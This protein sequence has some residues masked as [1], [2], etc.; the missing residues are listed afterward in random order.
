MLS[1]REISN[2]FSLLAKLME[3][4]GENAFKSRSN[5]NAAF[6]IGRMRQ[7]IAELDNTEL[8]KIDGIGK[9]T[10]VKIRELIDEGSIKELDALIE[11]TPAGV[12]DMMG[13][14][15]IGPKKIAVIW[16]ELGIESPGELL[17]ACNENRLI[18]LKGFGKKTQDQIIKTIEFSLSNKDK[19]HFASVEELSDDLLKVI[20]SIKECKQCSLSGDIRRK[21]IVI[22]DIQIV[23]SATDTK[24][25]YSALKKIFKDAVIDEGKSEI[26]FSADSGVPVIISV[27]TE[28][29][30]VNQV[31]AQ[32]AS[33]K[34]LADL[35]K[36]KPDFLSKKKYKNEDDIY[37]DLGLQTIPA[38]MREGIGEVQLAKKN[39]IPHLL[40]DKDLKGIL[41]NHT[42]YS[43]GLHSLRE[44]AE[45]CKKL[46]YEYLGICDHSKS[47]FYANGLHVDRIVEQHKEIDKLNEELKPFKIFKGIESDILNNGDLDY[48]PEVL[49]SF[50]MIVASI[51]SN[52]KMDSN[53]ATDRLLKAIENPFTTILG[54]PT[55]RLL[56]A[57]EGYPIDHKKV[58]D[59]CA[60]NNV[61]IELNAH[62]YRLDLD[63]SWIPYALKK[64]VMI[65]INPDAHQIEGYYDMHYGVCAARK[66]GLPADM[67][68]N[69]LGLEKIEK[70]FTKRKESAISASV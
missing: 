12:I 64:K 41:H 49:S 31:F 28:A 67:T 60:A 18:E 4:H 29:E 70:Y 26:N 66:G 1:N 17:Y 5:A 20:S 24:K 7:N 27:C 9:G 19:F 30:Y 32:T 33:E 52:L 68:F 61:I 53:K 22:D 37:K 69:A 47:A 13:I 40:E 21:S 43:D 14:K 16:N 35:E 42:T 38:E 11:K 50:D 51:H 23:C 59:A 15:G 57:R 2:Q 8:A 46:G 65:S 44:M 39:A 10:I 56:L 25:L 62:P 45:A 6:R 58:I 48:D 3:L 54:H 63:W 55:G 34:H 36:I